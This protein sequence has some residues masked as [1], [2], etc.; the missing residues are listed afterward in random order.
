M[1]QFHDASNGTRIAYEKTDGR[2]PTV[3]FCGG[4]KSDMSGTKATAL[5]SH[6]RS[7]GQAYLRFDYGGH[8]ESSGAFTD[9]TIGQWTDDALAA[10]DA[11]TDGPLI[12]IGSS[13]GGWIA[14]LVALARKDRLAG[15]IGL[16]AAPD[17]T[18]RLMWD[19]FT[20]DQRTAIDTD[21][22]VDLPSDYDDEPYRITKGLIED[23]RNHL[24][25]DAE[26]DLDVPVRL[27]HGQ[28]DQDVPC[29]ISFDIMDKISG[30]D[31]EVALVKDGVHN[32][33]EP[34]DLRRMTMTLDRILGTGC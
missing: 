15:L 27:I 17:F 34:D 23:G 13:M 30:G 4:F 6:C 28:K 8:G 32:L 14:L 22:F 2:A 19:Q 33:S 3:V 9:G 26:I 24:L 10:I 5:E 1:P 31:V 29:Q 21:G 16:A 12:L 20:D 7:I 25:M 18:Q 11:L